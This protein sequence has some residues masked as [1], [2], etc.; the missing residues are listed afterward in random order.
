MKN[1]NIGEYSNIFTEV[2]MKYLLPFLLIICM[3]TAC[4]AAPAVPAAENDVP[5][6][7]QAETE[8]TAFDNPPIDNPNFVTP[9]PGEPGSEDNPWLVGAKNP[10]DVEAMIVEN[11]LFVFGY[12]P[13]QD[14]PDPSLRPW[15]SFIRSLSGLNV[16]GTHIGQ[17]AFLDF[18]VEAESTNFYLSD[19]ITS[20]GE[21]A[22]ENA[23]MEQLHI[24]ESVTEIGS[25]AFANITAYCI[26]F[27]GKPLI[28]EDAFAGTSAMT[29]VIPSTGWQEADK[30]SYGGNLDYTNEFNF[31]YRLM[32]DGEEIGFGVWTLPEGQTLLFNAMDEVREDDCKFLYYELTEGKIPLFNPN[33]QVIDMPLEE[34]IT[35]II[36]YQSK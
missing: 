31:S 28:A 19:G 33:E 34:D 7:T 2:L 36:H 15:H 16:S 14:F 27:G 22:F 21:G 18:G 20:I 5:V 4:T 8:T 3:L 35:V 26:Y 30:R 10:G 1:G 29:F 6:I 24:P 13:M 32:V 11:C 9:A 17:N 12:G 25:R 23:V